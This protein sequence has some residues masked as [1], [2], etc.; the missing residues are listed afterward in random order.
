MEYKC[1]RCAYQTT[2][3]ANYIRHLQSNIPCEAKYEDEPRSALIL[4]VTK[5]ERKG[6]SIECSWCGKETSKCHLA[7]HRSVCRKRADKEGNETYT[8]IQEESQSLVKLLKETNAN[9]QEENAQLKEQLSQRQKEQH[10][11]CVYEV[12][13]QRQTKKKKIPSGVRKACWEKYVG[14]LGSTLCLCCK[15]NTISVWDFHCS[16]VVAESIGGL[17]QI[18]NLRPICARCN[19]DMGTDNMKDF[20]LRVYGITI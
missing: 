3:K 1:S 5:R 6:A 14:D 8:E 12:Q 18:D 17:I 11:H 9:L 15:L 13:P 16:H 2:V 4:N 20:A 7:R 10:T 19:I